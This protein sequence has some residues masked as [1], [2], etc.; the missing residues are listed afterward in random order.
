MEEHPP[1]HH[2]HPQA[3]I[4]GCGCGS[5]QRRERGVAFPLKV[6]PEQ[7]IKGTFFR[8]K[9]IRKQTEAFFIIKADNN[10]HC[11]P[12]MRPAALL[13]RSCWAFMPD[14]IWHWWHYFVSSTFF[15]LRASRLKEACIHR[16]LRNTQYSNRP[17]S[18]QH[19]SSPPQNSAIPLQPLNRFIDKDQAEEELCLS[20]CTLLELQ[21]SSSYFL[22]PNW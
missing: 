8:G 2:P 9:S 17:P 16:S 12:S 15:S 14:C 3:L 6:T 18:P 11:A 21:R 13:K 1:S 19:P 4:A 22:I 20:V 7:P 5:G 10:P